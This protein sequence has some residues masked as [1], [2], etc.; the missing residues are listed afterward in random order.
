MG[1]SFASFRDLKGIGP[2]TE[3]RLHET[4]IY[5]WEALAVAAT[6]LAAVRGE[7]ET[8]RDVANAV[9]ARRADAEGRGAELHPPG[10]GERLESF[11]LRIALT[12]DGAPQRCEVTHVR[13]MAGHAWAGWS[14]GEL[15]HFIQEHSGF[16]LGAALHEEPK[17]RDRQ[18]SP[19]ARRRP[20]PAPRPLSP[21]H[22]V[23]LDAGKAIGGASRDLNFVIT[24]THAVN[25][26]FSYRATLAARA[27][28]TG[29]NGEGWSTVA[30]LAGT[31]SPA[32]GLALEFPAVQLPPGIHRLQLRMEVKLPAPTSRPALALA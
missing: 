4:G 19:R 5:T 6:A 23:V 29:S 21:D 24:S 27:L 7:G 30:G 25:G 10:G 18:A 15:A 22:L 28:G 32:R 9:A 8:L 1:D 14:P 31:G 13:T 20:D 3:A 16:R 26:D 12:A 2:A 17:K 11:L